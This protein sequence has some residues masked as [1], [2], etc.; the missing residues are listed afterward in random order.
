MNAAQQSPSSLNA[1]FRLYRNVNVLYDVM[2]TVTENAGAFGGKD[3]YAALAQDLNNLDMARRSLA[4]AMEA[5]TAQRDADWTRIQ[6]AAQR[7]QQQAASAPPPK[8]V[9]IDDNEQEKK[10]APKKKKAPAT[11]APP[12]Q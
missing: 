8:K 2:G 3:E 11:T 1:S 10:P 9:V 4:D 12:K 7:A 6:Q 5:M